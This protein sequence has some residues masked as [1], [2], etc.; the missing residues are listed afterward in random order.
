M[1]RVYGGLLK[2][3]SEWGLYITRAGCWQVTCRTNWTMVSRPPSNTRLGQSIWSGREC[4]NGQSSVLERARLG[5][6]TKV[7]VAV[8][9]KAL[10]TGF[11]CGTWGQVLG[12]DPDLRR[13]LCHRVGFI[14]VVWFFPHHLKGR[15]GLS[16]PVNDPWSVGCRWESEITS[17]YCEWVIDSWCGQSGPKGLYL[18]CIF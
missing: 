8:W 14:R 15:A 1:L 16:A 4:S 6:S 18:C 17:N 7:L 12:I 9:G 3:G 2:V 13:C 11:G 5:P 10:R